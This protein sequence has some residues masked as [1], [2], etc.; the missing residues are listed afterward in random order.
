MII[1]CIIHHH[2][3]LKLYK[4]CF[5]TY[6]ISQFFLS[7][8]FLFFF[9]EFSEFF[10]KKTTTSKNFFYYFSVLHVHNIFFRYPFFSSI[11]II[12][13]FRCDFWIFSQ[14]T[15]NNFFIIFFQFITIFWFVVF[16]FFF[17]FTHVKHSKKHESKKK[18]TASHLYFHYFSYFDWVF[19]YFSKYFLIY[20]LV[21][22][23]QFFLMMVGS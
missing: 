11:N 14:Y 4:I 10:Q 1:R 7:L 15:Y 17:I 9:C 20:F 13:K 21:I 12:L 6:K 22:Y 3:T 8:D 23:R 19:F 5:I 16:H 18:S 2:L